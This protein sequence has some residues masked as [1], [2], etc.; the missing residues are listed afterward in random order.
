LLFSV[1][2][3]LDCTSVLSKL[4]NFFQKSSASKSKTD[5]DVSDEEVAH[6]MERVTS[7]AVSEPGAD[8]SSADGL[9]VQ[10]LT[11]SFGR[12]TAVDNVSFGVKRGEVFAL[13]GPNG[14]CIS[15]AV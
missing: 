10:H 8:A 12:N 7:H 14:V 6:E 1:L 3:W 4:K 15:N 13:L 2:L 11:K 9:Q 5:P